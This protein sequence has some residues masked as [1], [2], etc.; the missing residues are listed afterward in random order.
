[1]NAV[2]PR[3]HEAGLA[4]SALLAMLAVLLL[5]LGTGAVLLTGANGPLSIAQTASPARTPA[6]AVTLAVT[7]AKDDV[8]PWYHPLRFGIAHGTITSVSALGPDGLELPGTLTPMAWTGTATLIPGQTYRIHAVV[9]DEDGKTSSVDRELV[10]SPPA[11]VL[12]ASISPNGG[13]YGV[14]Q[15]VVVRFDQPVK[16]ADARR[17]VL[18]RLEVTAAPSVAGAW[19]WYNSFE[20]HYRGPAYWKPGTKVT[21]NATLAGLRVPGSDAWGSDKPV[22][23]GFS[24]GRSFLGVVDINAHTMT[25]TQDGKVVRVMKVS[26]GRAQY[27]TKGGVHIVLVREREHLYNSATIGIPTASPGGYYEKLPYSVRISNGG[28]FVHANPATVRYQ[29]SRNVSHGCVNMSVADARWYYENSK[30]GDVVNVIHAVV[31]PL[32]TDAGMSDWNYTWEQWQAG[33]L[34]G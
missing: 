4:R 6:P 5:A 20:V 8:V 32:R 17:A 10:A 1:M 28:A 14:G 33:N 25:V 7:S 18:Q 19:R 2:D 30:L 34:D 9:R 11:K 12:H 16:G 29:G 23:G 24:V 26:T 3:H 15:P 13:V 31:P 22:T 27:P 21:V